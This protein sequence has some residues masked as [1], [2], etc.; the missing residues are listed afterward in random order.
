[1]FLVITINLST[2]DFTFEK[3]NQSTDQQYQLYKKLM[4]INDEK[5]SILN[6]KIKRKRLINIYSF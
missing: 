1:M 5:L 6:K 4:E 3:K 2:N